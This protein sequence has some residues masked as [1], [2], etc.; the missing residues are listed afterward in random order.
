MKIEDEIIERMQRLPD[1]KQKEVLR[2]VVRLRTL[3]LLDDSGHSAPR[4]SRASPRA[5]ATKTAAPAAA[6]F[7][8]PNTDRPDACVSLA[9]AGA[10]PRRADCS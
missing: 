3:E 6:V 8:I 5:K 9:E 4:T 7:V 10:A 1:E 2:F